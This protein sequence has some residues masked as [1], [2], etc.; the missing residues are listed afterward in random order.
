MRCQNC[1]FVNPN[2]AGGQIIPSLFSESYFLVKKGVWWT[3]ISLLFLNHY[4]LLDLHLEG[5]GTLCPPHSS[6]IQKPKVDCKRDINS[7]NQ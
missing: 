7:D 1:H 5:A 2:G 4:E 3:K 6:Y